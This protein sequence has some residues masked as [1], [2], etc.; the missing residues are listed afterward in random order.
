M[1]RCWWNKLEKQFQ[2]ITS[3]KK[4]ERRQ[5]MNGFTWIKEMLLQNHNFRMYEEHSSL[6]EKGIKVFA[7][8]TDAFHIR[9]DFILILGAGAGKKTMLRPPTEKYFG[10]PTRFRKYQSLQILLLMLRMNGIRRRFVKK[11]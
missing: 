9:R 8:K 3:T 7:A 2:S 5:L 10:S 1:E 11:P 4:S 6:K